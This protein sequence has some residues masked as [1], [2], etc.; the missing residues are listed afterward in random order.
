MKITKTFLCAVSMFSLLTANA[1]ESYSFRHEQDID[2]TDSGLPTEIETGQAALLTVDYSEAGF[3]DLEFGISEAGLYAQTDQIEW[4]TSINSDGYG[5]LNL[6][7]L[8]DG[9]IFSN[10]ALRRIDY[11]FT[12]SSTGEVLLP[13]SF[14]DFDEL[15]DFSFTFQSQSGTTTQG[16]VIY[17]SSYSQGSVSVFVPEPHYSPLYAL[18]AFVFFIKGFRSRHLCR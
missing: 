15:A 16:V 9:V 11:T 13:A 17:N 3:S 14:Q 4:S 12:T 5:I 10:Q 1:G 18:F 6:A 8:F 2:F 7:G